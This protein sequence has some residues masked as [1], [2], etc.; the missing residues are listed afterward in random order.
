MAADK[1]RISDLHPFENTVAG[2][3]GVMADPTGDLIIKPCAPAEVAF[4]EACAIHP[5]FNAV[6]PTFMGTLSLSSDIEKG[7]LEGDQ[8]VSLVARA[9]QASATAP[10]GAPNSRGAKINTQQAIV[11]ENIAAGFKKPNILDVKLG[12]RLW[13]DDASPEKRNKLDQVSSETTSGS[14]GFR[15]AGMRVWQPG[16]ENTVGDYRV[17]DKQYGRQFTSQSVKQA[18]EEFFLIEAGKGSEIG[19]SL[20]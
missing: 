1:L 14:L 10:P 15:I 18:F 4:Y 12:I 13:A 5:I 2:H 8:D 7:A 9:V 20:L 3:D 6:V 17:Y 16:E 11:L 19:T